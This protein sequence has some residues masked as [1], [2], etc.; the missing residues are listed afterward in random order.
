VVG[1]GALP[2]AL[3]ANEKPV[4]L[5]IHLVAIGAAAV[6][7]L[8]LFLQAGSAAVRDGDLALFVVALFAML[9][10]SA[11]YNG[12]PSSRRSAFLK[13]VDHASIF[14]LIA[15]TYGPFLGAASDDPRVAAAYVVVWTI[16]A[17]GIALKL[18]APPRFERLF[19][20]IYLALGWSGLAVLD[21][22]IEHLPA[23][24]L[25][26]IGIGGAF[27]TIGVAFHLA[28]RLRYGT[29]IWHSFV[30]CAAATHFGAVFLLLA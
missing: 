10:T 18:L 29:T 3:A 2:R 7:T 23:A 20:V 21:R 9:V 8:L 28:P 5:A 25:I 6:A 24:S 17:I 30:V 14:F 19:V 22:L 11:V 15:A 27:Y 26:L 12:V 13:R 1:G 4:D 16:A